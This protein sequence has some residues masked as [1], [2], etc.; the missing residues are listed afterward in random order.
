VRVAIDL[1]ALVRNGWRALAVG[2]ALLFSLG[3]AELASQA[4]SAAQ[5][6][7]A[8][9]PGE[10]VLEMKWTGGLKPRL[11]TLVVHSDGHFSRKKPFEN[12][13]EE[14]T[15]ST[16]DFKRLSDAVLAA[17]FSAWKTDYDR[18][19]DDGCCDRVRTELKLRVCGSDG[20]WGL[21]DGSWY[22]LYAAPADL[23]AVLDAARF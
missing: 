6:E 9:N 3:C 15:L 23:R 7:R 16:V 8:G 10:W 5:D 20:K 22:S 4:A 18:Q 14:G 13:V 17:K 19:G 2:L 21:Y 1:E 11:A 12:T